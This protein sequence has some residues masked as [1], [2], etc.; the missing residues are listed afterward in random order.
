MKRSILMYYFLTIFL[1]VSLEGSAIT[2][3]SC[4]F[5]LKIKNNYDYNWESRNNEWKNTNNKVD[6]F[7]LSLSW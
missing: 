4:P 6:Y 7:M 2:Q 3:R 1:I 5:P